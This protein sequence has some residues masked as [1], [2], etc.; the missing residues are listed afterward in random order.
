MKSG[1][2][3]FMDPFAPLQAYSGTAFYLYITVYPEG[4]SFNSSETFV[5]SYHTTT[6]HSFQTNVIFIVTE[7]ST[8]DFI[9][10]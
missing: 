8:S 10:E 7:G 6:R 4:G 5:F 1:N 9:P 3:N 2:L